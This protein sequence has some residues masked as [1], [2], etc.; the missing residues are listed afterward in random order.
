[1]KNV[2]YVLRLKNN[3][4]FIAML[5]DKGYDVIFSKGNEFLR[6]IATGQVTKIRIQVKN[7]YKKEVEELL[8]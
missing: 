4:V 2:M 5:E 1:M 3:L 6:H 7:I 8:L